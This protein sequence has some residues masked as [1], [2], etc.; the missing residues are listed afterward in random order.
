[1]RVVIIGGGVSGL[2]AAISAKNKKNQVLILERNSKCC[3]KLLLTGNGRCNY[4]NENQSIKFYHSSNN[5]LLNQVI[6]HDNLLKVTSFFN[7]I[8]IVPRIKEGYYYPYSNQSISIENA[9]ILTAKE[10]GIEIHTDTFVESVE[11]EGDLFL[12]KTDNKCYSAEKVVISVG[13]M[14]YPKTGSDGNFYKILEGMG[15]TIIKPLP[16]LV[17]LNAVGSF[18]KNWSGI[19]VE[20]NIKLYEDFSYV[21]E[22][23]GELLLTNYGVSGICVMQLSGFVSRGLDLGKT[24]ELVIN[25]LPAFCTCR[26]DFIRLLDERNK[27]LCLR[28]ISELLDTYLPYKLVNILIQYSSISLHKKWNNLS[29]KEKNELAKN[30][31]EFHLPVCGT[32]SFNSAQITSGG[33]SLLDIDLLTMQSRLIK[34]LYVTGEVLDVNGDCGGYNL[35]FAFLSGILAGSDICD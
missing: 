35:T 3:K 7:K 31:V 15:H 28:D 33:V 18:L 26:D 19:R 2:A 9:L 5:E 6:Y 29:F 20:A 12:I 1:M 13:G 34:D 21:K 30:F 32:N 23:T 22:E 16:A 8:G 27:S 14:S 4:Y 24:E 11:K 17:Q 10:K 25:F